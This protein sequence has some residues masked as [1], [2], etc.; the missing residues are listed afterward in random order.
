[1]DRLIKYFLYSSLFILLPLCSCYKATHLTNP[2]APTF[3]VTA[4]VNGKNNYLGPDC[5]VPVKKGAIGWIDILFLRIDGNPEH[6]DIKCSL[7]ALPTG[8]TYSPESY[9]F[10]LNCSAAFTI[11]AN[12]ADTGLYPANVLVFTMLYGYQNYMFKIHVIQ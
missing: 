8:V 1:M 3:S 10:Q 2:V 6:F 7:S 4:W 12:T 11:N 5:I 9:T